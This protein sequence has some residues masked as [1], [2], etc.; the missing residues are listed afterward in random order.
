MTLLGN[1]KKLVTF[2]LTVD[3]YERLRD[4]C[5]SKGIRSISELTRDAVLQQVSTDR[6]S[7]NLVSGD[8]MALLASLEQID[9]AIKNLSGRISKVLG[10][11]SKSA[12]GSQVIPAKAGSR[13]GG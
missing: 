3:E 2:R 6:V 11:T 5:I 9:D 4:L 10:P 1:R 12:A 13:G 7:R 8:L